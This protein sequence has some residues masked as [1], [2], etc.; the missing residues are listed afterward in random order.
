MFKMFKSWR[1]IR[2][3]ALLVSLAIDGF[4]FYEA[5][6]F[7]ARGFMASGI[8]AA[9]L[10]LIVLEIALNLRGQGRIRGALDEKEKIVYQ[11]GRHLFDLFARVGKDRAAGYALSIPI[12]LAIATSVGV[13][14]LG[15][16]VHQ[17]PNDSYLTESVE[18]AFAGYLPLLIAIPFILEHV[19]EWRS[20]QYILAEDTESHIPR[21]LISHGVL[22][23]DFESVAL[24]RTVT[25]HL[26]QSFWDTL[27]DIGDI[28][29]RETAG[30]KA[31]VLECLWK[32]RAM[33]KQ[34]QTVINRWGRGHG[35]QVD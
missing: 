19:S 17:F 6:P 21:L 23:Y 11:V 12:L 14:W 1:S 29:I 31:E 25:T 35:T 2:W 33:A 18:Y 4:I 22:E 16:R 7:T 10:F 24:Q 32:P 5:G 8:G 28:E 27:V 20:W 34:I 26:H 15:W 9:L 30:G 13:L 3:L